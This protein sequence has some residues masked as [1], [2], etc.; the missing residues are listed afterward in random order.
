MQFLIALVIAT[1]PS[2]SLASE[3]QAEGNL[4]SWLLPIIT[5]LVL[6]I[7][8]RY[9]IRFAKKHRSESGHNDIFGSDGGSGD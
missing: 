1:Y 2:V 8:A 5:I 7:A 6:V 3:K 9:T 4:L